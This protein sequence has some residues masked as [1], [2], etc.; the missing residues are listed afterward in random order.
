MDQRFRST[1]AKTGFTTKGTKKT[2]NGMLP[3]W[4]S[5]PSFVPFVSFVVKHSLRG[6]L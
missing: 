4:I 5:T 3:Q 2:K 6:S 1:K